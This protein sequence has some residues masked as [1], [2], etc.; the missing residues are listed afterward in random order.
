[1]WGY[2]PKVFIIGTEAQQVRGSKQ[3]MNFSLLE[4]CVI[5]W[6]L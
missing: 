5:L 2:R 3:F 1:M 6:I 4:S